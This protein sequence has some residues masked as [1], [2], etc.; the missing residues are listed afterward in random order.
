MVALG[1]IYKVPCKGHTFSA[2]LYGEHRHL[3]D[4]C[5][6]DSCGLEAPH[7]F[8]F[9]SLGNPYKSTGAVVNICDECFE[10][11]KAE[12]EGVSL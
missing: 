2:K 11:C 1:G 4:W 7:Y 8:E 5:K 3:Y 12:V 10:N 6:C 9:V